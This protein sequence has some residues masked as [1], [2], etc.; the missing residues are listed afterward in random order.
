M[1]I[2]PDSQAYACEFNR[3]PHKTTVQNSASQERTQTCG[4]LLGVWPKL[5]FGLHRLI[6]ATREN[7]FD[8]ESG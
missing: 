4:L 5:C 8:F 6:T 3:I 2:A 7:N 1:I